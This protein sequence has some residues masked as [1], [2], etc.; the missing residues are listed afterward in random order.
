MKL[1]DPREKAF[2][3][4]LSHIL[5]SLQG[6]IPEDLYTEL[7]INDYDIDDS[8]DRVKTFH[9]KFDKASSK[10]CAWWASMVK[11][12]EYATKHVKKKNGK[13]VMDK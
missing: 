3:K 11:L 5:L 8:D 7:E 2:I 6:D 12:N 10:R 9:R 1:N 4:K 13:Y